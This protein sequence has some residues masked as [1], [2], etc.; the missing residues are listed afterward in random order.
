MVISVGDSGIVGI[1]LAHGL[2]IAVMASATMAISGGHLNPAVT[3]GAYVAKKI[4]APL[5]GFYI[6]SQILGAVAASIL[7]K[8]MLPAT[9]GDPNVLG[10]PALTKYVTVGQGILIEAV[11]T[12]FLMFVVLG[13]AYSSKAAKVG[14]LFIGLTV[15]L[16]IL[17]SGPLTGAAL[18]PARWFGPALLSAN[19]SNAVVWTIG[20]IIGAILA[21]L[22]WP[23]VW[24]PKGE[25]D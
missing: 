17:W 1:A 16:D 23:V 15:T 11:G 10:L 22:L 2:T 4:E 24:A 25:E 12:F 9:M 20:P 18:N 3:V 7:A 14:G 21:G 5:A 8:L 6:V 13:T 19:L